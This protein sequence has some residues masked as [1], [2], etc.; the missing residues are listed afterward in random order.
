ML[1]KTKNKQQLTRFQQLV[2]QSCLCPK[3]TFS[4]I[5]NFDRPFY[6]FSQDENSAHPWKKKGRNFKALNIR[7][8]KTKTE[9][10]LKFELRYKKKETKS[11]TIP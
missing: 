8:K 11:S 2:S 9:K 5:A 1:S 4:S 3:K 7:Q 6:S 10:V